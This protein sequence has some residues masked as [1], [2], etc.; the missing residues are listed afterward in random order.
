MFY[1][2]SRLMIL[3]M[4][5]LVTMFTIAVYVYKYLEGC[6]TASA[7]LYSTNSLFIQFTNGS[8]LIAFVLIYF[9]FSRRNVTRFAVVVVHFFV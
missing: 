1:L 4:I 6:V 8:V 9:D 7:H 3:E 2:V 5:Q